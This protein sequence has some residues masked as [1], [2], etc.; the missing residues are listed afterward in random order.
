MV[1]FNGLGGWACPCPHSDTTVNL[2]LLTE[3]VGGRAE[4]KG[5]LH[6]PQGWGNELIETLQWGGPQLGSCC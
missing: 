6:G 2:E 1:L 4:V 3:W 5:G